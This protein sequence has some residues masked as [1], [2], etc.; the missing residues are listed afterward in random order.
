M[1]IYNKS[2][3]LITF[4]RGCLHESLWDKL[5]KAWLHRAFSVFEME[6][7]N[8]TVHGMVLEVSPVKQSRNNPDIK[9]LKISDGKKGS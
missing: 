7:G 1:Y 4:T 5:E 8:A 2:H 9:Y 3:I 6:E